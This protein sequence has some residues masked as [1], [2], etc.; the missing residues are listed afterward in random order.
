MQSQLNINKSSQTSKYGNVTVIK[1]LENQPKK[2]K[3]LLAFPI[4]LDSNNSDT[5]IHETGPRPIE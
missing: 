1:K 4:E 5:I 2:V 3:I